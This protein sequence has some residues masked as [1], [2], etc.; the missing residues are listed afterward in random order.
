MWV[1]FRFP[2]LVIRSSNTTT[3]LPCC[4]PVSIPSRP[5]SSQLPAI[6]RLIEQTAKF[7]AI[8]PNDST[9]KPGDDGSD[10]EMGLE[11]SARLTHLADYTT[12]AVPKGF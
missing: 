12:P 2:F 1:L 5:L 9:Y 3:I 4:S 8:R 11:S 7:N 6:L 10:L